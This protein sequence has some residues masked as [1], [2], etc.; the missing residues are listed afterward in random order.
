MAASYTSEKRLNPS[1]KYHR[2]ITVSWTSAADGS[3]SVALPNVNGWLIKAITDP[4]ATAPTDNYDI[5]LVDEAGADAAEGLLAN[6]DTANTE[7]VYTL[8]TG[9]A[10]PVFL[11]GTVTFTVANAGDSK[12]GTCYLYVVDSL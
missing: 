4:G 7:T 10:T 9:A 12:V 3:A 1:G 11:S 6:R 5:T 8:V 2:L